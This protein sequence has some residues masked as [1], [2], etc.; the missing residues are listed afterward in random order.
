VILFSERYALLSLKLQAFEDEQSRDFNNKY[1]LKLF[2]TVHG[3][4]LLGSHFVIL[5]E[6]T[7]DWNVERYITRDSADRAFLDGELKAQ[8]EQSN[9][10]RD[11]PVY[12]SFG[13]KYTKRGQ[14]DKMNQ[15]KSAFI[16]RLE[17][18]SLV[19]Q[20]FPNFKDLYDGLNFPQLAEEAESLLVKPNIKLTA[21]KRHLRDEG[22]FSVI[23]VKDRYLQQ[24]VAIP[25]ALLPS[26]AV[27]DWKDNFPKN[28]DAL[29]QILSDK[30]PPEELQKYYDDPKEMEKLF[31]FKRRGNVFRRERFSK[32]PLW[33]M[34]I[35]LKKWRTDR[36]LVDWAKEHE[37]S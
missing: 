26:M 12:S 24:N 15:T 6:G 10:S 20:S 19:Y 3:D 33:Q 35:M 37:R 17:K 36:A 14:A 11:S 23:R 4:N 32:V 2:T 22:G 21:W 29:I 8:I 30:Y 31:Y 28:M 27:S 25:C 34:E 16:R 5:D 18:H 9:A 7:N 13:K 1:R